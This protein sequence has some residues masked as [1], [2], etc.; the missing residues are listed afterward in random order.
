MGPRAT[1]FDENMRRDAFG[2]VQEIQQRQ[3]DTL[4]LPPSFVRK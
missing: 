3:I 1:Y 4:D 2:L